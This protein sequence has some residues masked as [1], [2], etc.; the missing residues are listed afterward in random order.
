MDDEAFRRLLQDEIERR[1]QE[2]NGSGVETR[3]EKNG[4]AA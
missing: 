2:G 4:S 3:V 1:L